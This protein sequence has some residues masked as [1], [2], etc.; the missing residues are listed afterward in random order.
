M[1]ER[2]P[3]YFDDFTCLA[4]TCPESC[5]HEWE[6]DIDDTSAELYRTLPGPLGDALRAVLRDE[7]G[8]TYMT[9]QDGRCPMWRNDGLCEIQ[10]QLGHDGLSKTC[11][12]YPRIS[13]DYGDFRELGLELSCPAAAALILRS[14]KQALLTIPRPADIPEDYDEECMETLLRSRKTL[15]QFWE[16]SDYS[17]PQMLAITYLYALNV[18]AEIDGGEASAFCT[19]Q[20]LQRGAAL[21]Q[22]GDIHSVF[23][24]F[25]QLEI[26]TDRWRARLVPEKAACWH[27]ET[28]NFVRYGLLRYYLQAVSDYDLLCRV[29]W[30]VVSALLLSYMEGDFLQ[31]AQLFSKEIEN[32]RDNMDTLWD[33]AY[34]CPAFSDLGLLGLLLADAPVIMK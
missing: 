15:L 19:E 27:P 23:H 24:R 11:R 4:G 6:V 34:T 13:H 7:D 14:D 20:L 5:C 29:K 9:I 28:K 22:P 12:E 30:L 33:D 17:I 26:L 32:S 2:K 18:Q 31:N 16:T 25:L 1:I 8:S 3:A 10:C 21:A